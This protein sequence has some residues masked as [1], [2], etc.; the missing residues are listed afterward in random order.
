M[1]QPQG[2]TPDKWLFEPT[3]G[4]PIVRRYL[5]C[6]A[7]VYQHALAHAWLL[8]LATLLEVLCANAMPSHLSWNAEMAPAID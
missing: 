5:K 3:L 8:L 6:A 2:V 1:Q 4:L 7:P